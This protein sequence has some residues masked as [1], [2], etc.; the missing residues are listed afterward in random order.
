MDDK[1]VQEQLAEHSQNINA[2]KDNQFSLVA[3]VQVLQAALASALLHQ[4]DRQAVLNT[5][6]QYMRVAKESAPGM[7]AR[8]EALQVGIASLLGKHQA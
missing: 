7:A 8:M 2:L 3:Q 6:E 4:P 5:F 1:D